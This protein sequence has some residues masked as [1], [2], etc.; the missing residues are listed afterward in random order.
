MRLDASS[1]KYVS[2][3][4]VSLSRIA[5]GRGAR[6][7]RPGGRRNPHGRR[8]DHAG[9]AGGAAAERRRRNASRR[10]RNAPRR[11]RK[12]RGGGRN[13]RAVGHRGGGAYRRGA[14]AAAP[15]RGGPAIVETVAVKRLCE[16]G[17]S[18]QRA[19]IVAAFIAE[20]ARAYHYGGWTRPGYGWRPAAPSRP[21]RR[22]ASSARRPPSSWAG[23][24]PGPGLCWYYTDPSRRQGF[25]DACQ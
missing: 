18:L 19:L 23:A 17:A 11:W 22:W 24:A 14:I 3:R 16:P 20:L 10:R 1:Q 8:P 25:W 4:F 7:L 9:E 12:H 5:G 2:W 21:A 13:A 6:D 15:S